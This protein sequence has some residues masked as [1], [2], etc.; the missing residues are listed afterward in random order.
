M[1]IPLAK[2]APDLAVYNSDSLKQAINTIPSE[3][4]YKPFPNSVVGSAALDA[5]ARGGTYVKD[6]EGN[7]YNYAGTASKLYRIETSQAVTN[8]SKAG[9]YVTGDEE[10]W[11]FIQWNQDLFATNF[12]DVIQ[13]LAVPSASIFSTLSPSAPKARYIAR[14]RDF[15]V[16]FNTQDAVDGVRTT[17]VW[18]S[19]LNDP[20]SWS[21]SVIT[22]ANFVDL[23]LSDGPGNGIVGGEYGVL[24]QER[25]ITRMSYIG[26]PEIFRYDKVESNRGTRYPNSIVPVGSLIFYLGLDGFYVFDGQ[27]SV[28]IGDGQVNTTVINDIN[29]SVP[30]RVVGRAD[31]TQKL[32]YW[33]YQSVAATT[34]DGVPDK[35][36]IYN[37]ED[38]TDKK[39]SIGN[40]HIQ[41]LVQ[42]AS[43][44]Y[45]L[46]GLDAVNTNLDELEPSLDSP[47]WQGGSLYISGYDVGNKLITF[48][49][50][51][52]NLTAIFETQEFEF[53]PS[54]LTFLKRIRIMCDAKTGVYVRVGM[55]SNLSEAVRWT[56]LQSPIPNV[57]DGT[58]GDVTLRANAR[59]LR[60]EL[61]ITG[62]YNDVQGIEI[63]EMEDSGAR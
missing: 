50:K 8:I 61:V 45:T 12:S 51:D 40:I 2:F 17:R 5:R 25:A 4:S 6:D 33:C 43:P 63:L 60:F 48:S 14:V 42:S 31:P 13:T 57:A 54:R 58:L 15:L 23:D 37:F 26:S 46:D 34:S 39:W 53:F 41:T 22:Q 27:N 47:F 3:N 35:I 16:A 11:N 44:G 19:A 28:G 52:E 24:F 36:V 56:G 38:G 9:G 30:K 18:N 55:R 7:S 49:N 32:V 21:A 59:Y 20:T 29:H 62:K 1:F 10:S